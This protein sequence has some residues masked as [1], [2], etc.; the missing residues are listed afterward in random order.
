MDAASVSDWFGLENNIVAS[1]WS[2]SQH[3]IAPFFTL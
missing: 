1:N 3:A 2:G